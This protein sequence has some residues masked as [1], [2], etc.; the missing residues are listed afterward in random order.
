M[1]NYQLSSIIFFQTN[2][3]VHSYN[4]RSA[5]KIHI[6]FRRTN[7]GKF[8]VDF[9]GAV[10]WNSLPTDIR[11]TNSFYIFKSK[12]KERILND[13]VWIIFIIYNTEI[14]YIE[15]EISFIVNQFIEYEV[16]LLL[17]I[18]LWQV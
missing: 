13:H 12:L 7:Y 11:N 18:Y 1:T 3:T 9:K 17:L 2:E 15:Q 4:T 10:T 14:I 8:S 6:E 16:H 5:S